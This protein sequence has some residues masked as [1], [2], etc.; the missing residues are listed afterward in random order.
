MNPFLEFGTRVDHDVLGM[1]KSDRFL[2]VERVQAR[3]IARFVSTCQTIIHLLCGKIDLML[4]EVR[5]GTVLLFEGL[6]ANKARG[7]IF[8]MHGFEFMLGL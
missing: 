2:N 6:E 4:A 3:V 1:M 5:D 7:W 8:V